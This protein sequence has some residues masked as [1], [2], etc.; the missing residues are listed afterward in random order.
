[1]SGHFLQLIH[2]IFRNNAN[3]ATLTDKA[4]VMAMTQ[5]VWND[6]VPEPLKSNSHA[7]NIEHKRLTVYVENGAVAAKLK[8]L[9]PSILTKLQKQG[10]A[11][12]SIRVQVQIKAQAEK[13]TKPNRTLSESA[14]K[15][16]DAL[17]NQ[18]EGTALGEVLKR[19]SKRRKP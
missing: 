16:I 5:K 1:M 8:L 17:A 10:L 19:L 14:A 12:S 13:T 18:V 6:V 11:I 2:A 7:G 9:L 4:K 3:F 15:E